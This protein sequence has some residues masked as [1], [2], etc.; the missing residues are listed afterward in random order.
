MKNINLCVCVESILLLVAL[1]TYIYAYICNLAVIAICF[2]LSQISR[3]LFGA[4]KGAINIFQY[5]YMHVWPNG[6][7]NVC[8]YAT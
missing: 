6:Y 5:S 2:K 8:V 3:Y 4:N 1:Y 7:A